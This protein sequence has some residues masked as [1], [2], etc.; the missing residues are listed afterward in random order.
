LRAE[1]NLDEMFAADEGEGGNTV[2]DGKG[3]GREG[4][5]RGGMD[6]LFELAR[7]GRHEG[8]EA[9]ISRCR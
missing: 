9:I 2:D 4:R 1:E 7:D 6:G 3:G 8:R 5:G